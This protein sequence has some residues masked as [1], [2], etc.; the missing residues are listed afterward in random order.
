MVNKKPTSYEDFEAE[1]LSRP[2]VRREYD[3][4]KSKYDIIRSLVE[5]R[6]QLRLSQTALAGKVGTK[7]PAISRLETGDCDVSLNTLLRVAAALQLDISLTAREGATRTS[8][9]VPS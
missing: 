9:K 6:S 4:L 8:G 7:Q 5:R 2:G 1:L 3:L